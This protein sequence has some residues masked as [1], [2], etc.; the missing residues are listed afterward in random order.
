MYVMENQHNKNAQCTKVKPWV[1]PDSKK[2]S[3]TS[4]WTGLLLCP[5]LCSFPHRQNIN[6]N[7]T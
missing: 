5:T 2:K 7:R 1:Q 6:N 3:F 4:A